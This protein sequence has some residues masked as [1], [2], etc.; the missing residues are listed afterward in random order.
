MLLAVSGMLRERPAVT[1]Q[2]ALRDL[3]DTG[4]RV[5]PEARVVDDGDVLTAGGVSAAIDLA[6]HLV[7]RERG[8]AAARAGARRIEHRPQGPVVEVL[9]SP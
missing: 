4:A 2:A 8:A 9:S 6:L 7:R 5:H 1:H 3:F